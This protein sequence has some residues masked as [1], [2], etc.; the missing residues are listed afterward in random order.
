MTRSQFE[1]VQI[2]DCTLYLG[3]CLEILP[4]LAPVDLLVTDSPYKVTSGGVGNLEGGFSGWIKDSYDNKGSIVRCDLDW[5]D[6]LGAAYA[7][8]TESAQAYIFS[9]D[10]NLS[11]A[12]AAA[13]AVG[14]DFH[15]L[16]T[17]D[18]KT[19][20]PNRWYIQ[21]CEF[22]LFMK[23]GRARQINDC[24]TMALQSVFQ[25]DESNHPTEKPVS[26]VEVYV[27]NSTDHGQLVLDPFM[28]SGTTGVACANLGRKFV[29]IEIDPGHFETACRRIERAYANPTLLIERPKPLRQGAML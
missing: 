18:K 27:R 26:L 11:I 8:L 29:G 7:A 15:R 10:R 21:N 16:L 1:S 24:G 9:N 12:R 23:K 13:E 4:T 19:A 22:V 25:R 17:W 28:G 6:W 20:L 3:D 5:S 14:F 2:G